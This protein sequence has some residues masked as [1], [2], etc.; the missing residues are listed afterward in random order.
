MWVCGDG[1]SMNGLGTDGLMDGPHPLIEM[2]GRIL[3]WLWM[4][5][6]CVGVCR[7]IFREWAMN[8]W[9][10]GWTYPLREMRGHIE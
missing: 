3:Q 4:V 2:G 8:G 5:S 6:V 1:F 10:D 7:M 9:T